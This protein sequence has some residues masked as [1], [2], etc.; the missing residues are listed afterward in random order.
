MRTKSDERR[1]KILDVAAKIFCKHG[2]E[3]TSMSD[4]SANVGGSKAT[5]YNYFKSKEEIF[6][7][8]AEKFADEKQKALAEILENSEGDLSLT[9]FAY[10]SK[11]VEFLTRPEII[12]ARRMIVAT[13]T[14]K[15]IANFFYEKG[16]RGTYDTLGAF[17]SSQIARGVIKDDD[18]IWIARQFLALIVHPLSE[19]L[20]FQI[21]T[22]IPKEEIEFVV[23]SAVDMII[24]RYGIKSTP[25]E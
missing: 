25:I 5:I 2:F 23:H 10:G 24:S 11:L 9:L 8:A 3:N 17:I 12:A 21:R 20:L 1:Q 15:K 7:C 16:P 14:P 18:P 19:S 6:S 22:K 4:I 13:N